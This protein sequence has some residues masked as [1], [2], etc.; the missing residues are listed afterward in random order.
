M[1]VGV[2]CGGC[3][4]CSSAGRAVGRSE[5]VVPAWLTW[6]EGSPGYSSPTSGPRPEHKMLWRDKPPAPPGHK[7]C[8]GLHHRNYT[9]STDDFRIF[10]KKLSEL[11]T[12]NGCC[13]ANEQVRGHRRSANLKPQPVRGTHSPQGVVLP[14]KNQR[15]Q[16]P[17]RSL[18]PQPVVDCTL[19]RQ[20][21]GE[22]GEQPCVF[23]VDMSGHPGDTTLRARRQ[24]LT[25][26]L[27]AVR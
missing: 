13:D 2:A 26:V 17:F 4:A 6:G 23:P 9:L 15:R 12:T 25:P 16:P 22:K 5:V 10:E 19:R 14:G 20:A 1:C 8:E 18:A 7:M 24:P 21:C 11:P 3:C 27:G